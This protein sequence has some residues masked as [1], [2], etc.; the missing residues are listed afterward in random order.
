MATLPVS[1]SLV[2]IVVGGAAII[3]SVYY[4]AREYLKGRRGV[5][6]V[7]HSPFRSTWSKYL[8]Y[9]FGEDV[10]SISQSSRNGSVYPSPNDTC[11]S[12]KPSDGNSEDEQ[13]RDSVE[14]L[15]ETCRL[16]VPG[17]KVS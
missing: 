14:D 10:G 13:V 12:S 4:V 15:L 2:L 7:N 11:G 9:V 1:R 5:G 8:T 3:T 6:N 17:W 16:S